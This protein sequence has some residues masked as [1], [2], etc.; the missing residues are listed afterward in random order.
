MELW[1]NMRTLTFLSFDCRTMRLS[2]WVRDNAVDTV[3][4]RRCDI[5]IKALRPAYNAVVANRESKL[6]IILILSVML[7]G[8]KRWNSWEAAGL[9]GCRF[10]DLPFGGYACVMGGLCQNKSR[11]RKAWHDRGESF[12]LRQRTTDVTFLFN[13][14][15]HWQHRPFF[16]FRFITSF[17]ANSSLCSSVIVK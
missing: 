2:A 9:S 8:Y 3:S 7:L 1:K 5:V 17:L 16:S 11:K 14:T 4:Q 12:P 10:P 15:V 13:Y 6:C